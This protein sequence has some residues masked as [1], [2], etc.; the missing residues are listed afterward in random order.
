MKY[1]KTTDMKK[2]ITAALLIVL[3][4]VL[5]AQVRHNTIEGSVEGLETG[6]RI[7]LYTGTLT[8]T[9]IAADSTTVK[10]SGKF[11]LKTTATDTYAMVA[12][13]KPGQKSD[14]NQVA[15]LGLF[16]EG[17]GKINL[18]GTAADWR[19]LKISGGLYSLPQMQEVNALT[20]KAMEMQKQGIALLDKTRTE[21]ADK[22][23]V[24]AWSDKG[25][26][27]LGKS[28]E[29]F[30]QRKALEKNISEA[31]PDLAY[32]AEILHY[33]YDLMKKG[34]DKYEEAFKALSPRVQACPAG[35]VVADFIATQKATAIG[36]E[37]PDFSLP[38]IDGNMLRLSDFRGKYVL[39]DFWGTWCGPCRQSTPHLVE[40][41][42]KVKGRNFEMISIATNERSDDYWR[43]VVS[44]DKMTW[45]QLNDAH[46]PA[47]RKI[48]QTY[49]VMGVP[50]CFFIDPHGVIIA[51]GHP[52]G[53][54][55][56]VEEVIT[57]PK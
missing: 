5:A 16:L 13:F 41:Y 45:R 18:K 4:A 19:Y 25:R 57:A 37:A 21:G 11:T 6:D 53:L 31:H 47:D 20:E 38:D 15:T 33:D 36:A 43:K 17:Y 51:K 55:K 40:L 12:F 24:K 49:G 10:T 22:D 1:I 34:M 7:I 35:K 9:P 3:P 28:N 27:L 29:I 52:M 2:I 39:L 46:S 30:G 14:I 32:S 54:L 23:S 56:K 42:S 44:D 26:A 48:Q 8:Q 50:S